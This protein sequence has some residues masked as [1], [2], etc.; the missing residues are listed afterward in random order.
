[1]TRSKV[2]AALNDAPRWVCFEGHGYVA[3]DDIEPNSAAEKMTFGD[4]ASGKLVKQLAGAGIPLAN[5]ERI[6]PQ[7]L[8]MLAWRRPHPRCF[9]LWCCRGARGAAF[10]GEGVIGFPRALHIAGFENVLTSL[11]DVS[12]D[13]VETIRNGFHSRVWQ[14]KMAISKAICEVQRECI[15]FGGGRA[16][17]ELWAAW[18]VTGGLE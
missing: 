17:P 16:H 15:R 9:E 3:S 1:M 2:I 11:W 10:S 18:I 7:D 6:V 13:D 4:H 8:M 12:P 14:N 5:R